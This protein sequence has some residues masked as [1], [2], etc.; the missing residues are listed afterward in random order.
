VIIRSRIPTG[1]GYSEY[2][3]QWQ[4]YV[5]KVRRILLNVTSKIESL[6]LMEPKIDILVSVPDCQSSFVFFRSDNELLAIRLCSEITQPLNNS[7]MI[8]IYF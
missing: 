7:P 2:K 5:T 6:I 1:Y 8:D 3:V 4:K